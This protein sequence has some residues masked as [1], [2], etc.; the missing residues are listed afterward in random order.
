MYA[1]PGFVDFSMS[2]VDVCAKHCL[3][4]FFCIHGC[5]C[6]FAAFESV[7]VVAAVFFIFAVCVVV[8]CV[9]VV[10]CVCGSV[11]FADAIAVDEAGCVA[12]V[13]GWSA[14]FADFFAFG[15]AIFFVVVGSG[16]AGATADYAV[17]FIVDVET[18]ASAG[19]GRVGGL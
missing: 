10:G 6:E 8:G 19:D 7:D 3:A 14:D 4:L 18:I 9:F 2:G 16:V 13:F 1:I 15:G 11:A 17:D 12:A 5:F